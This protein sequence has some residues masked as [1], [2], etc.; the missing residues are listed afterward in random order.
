MKT[1]PKENSLQKFDVQIAPEEPVYVISVV[2]Q[3]VQIPVWTLRK[4]DQMGVVQPKRIGKKT[5]CYSTVQV[6]KLS[7]VHYLMETKHVNISGIKI[8]LEMEF[9]A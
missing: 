9:K 4:L 7:Y 1:T 6:K 3:L 2:S 8:I 5:R